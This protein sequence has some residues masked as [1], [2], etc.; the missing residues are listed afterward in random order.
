MLHISEDKHNNIRV[1]LL[2]YLGLK[3]IVERYH[4]SRTTVSSI[5]KKYYPDL[6]HSQVDRPGVLSDQDYCRLVHMVTSDPPESSATAAKRLE[7]SLNVYNSDGAVH[8]A[9]YESGLLAIK[10]RRS[11]IYQM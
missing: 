9:L 1:F 7:T 3:A 11:H 5:R 2:E 6:A 8:N 10:K 4:V